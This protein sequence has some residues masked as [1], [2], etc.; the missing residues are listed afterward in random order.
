MYK[1]GK[2]I[3]VSTI[4]LLLLFLVFASCAPA[5]A[6]IQDAKVV[7]IGNM[8]GMTGPLATMIL[9]CHL[10]E[11]DYARWVNENGGINGVMIDEKWEDTQ[12]MVPKRITALRRFKDAMVIGII[13]ISSGPMESMAETYKGSEYRILRSMP[14]LR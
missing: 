10:A 6:P 2:G 11:I 9:W 5:S 8:C 13:E 1:H 3:R 7:R 12:G 4:A 14:I